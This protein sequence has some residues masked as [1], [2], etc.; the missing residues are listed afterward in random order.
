MYGGMDLYES[1]ECRSLLMANISLY[2][3]VVVSPLLMVSLIVIK[4]WETVNVLSIR[5]SPSYKFRIILRNETG[6][7][8][9]LKQSVLNGARS[10]VHCI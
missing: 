6:Y 8:Y 9:A 5:I 2:F 7:E 3:Y 1:L 4:K 10:G